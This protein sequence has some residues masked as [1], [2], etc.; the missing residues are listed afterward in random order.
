MGGIFGLYTTTRC[1]LDTAG[2][3]A[4]APFWAGGLAVAVPYALDPA[5]SDFLR[6][7]VKDAVRVPI[8][9]GLSVGMAAFSGSLVFGGADALLRSAGIGW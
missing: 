2:M 5:R 4:S 1:V 3:S 6:K 7:Y 9:R 8:G